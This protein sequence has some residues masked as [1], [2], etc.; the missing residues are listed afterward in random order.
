MRSGRQ[1][2][3][4]QTRKQKQ[5]PRPARTVCR[6]GTE[7]PFCSHQAQLLQ[8]SASVGLTVKQWVS[9]KFATERPRGRGRKLYGARLG[10]SLGHTGRAGIQEPDSHP[11]GSL[12]SRHVTLSG[13]GCNNG[14]KNAAGCLAFQGLWYL[15]APIHP[16]QAHTPR[17]Y[18]GRDFCLWF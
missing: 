16:S 7:R 12:F 13:T 6:G 8:N 9:C 17:E 4:I 2:H 15:L 11:G 10:R 5:E 1:N 3:I 14:Y 18:G